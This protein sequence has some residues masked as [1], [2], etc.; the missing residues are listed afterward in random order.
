MFAVDYG[1]T[2]QVTACPHCGLP[3]EVPCQTRAS[4]AIDVHAEATAPG[5]ADD[6][7][8]AAQA[9]PVF[10]DDPFFALRTWDGGDARTA[11]QETRYRFRIE[12][13]YVGGSGCCAFGCFILVAILLLAVLGFISLL[14]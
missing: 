10:D 1:L 7:V 8:L 4:Q 3:F 13:S 6:R 12:R 9:A 2:G 11:A 5:A 14:S